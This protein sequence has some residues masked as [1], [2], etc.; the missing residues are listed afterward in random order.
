M[1]HDMKHA[2]KAVI[3]DMDGTVLDTLSE[4]TH[5]L[6]HI[7]RLHHL[8]ELPSQ[9]VRLCLGYGYT[10]LIE[11]A[12]PSVPAET[13]A[14]LAE[15]FKQYYSIHCQGNTHPYNGVTDMLSALR[16]GGY[17]TAIV[18]N[19]GQGAVSLLHDEF[20]H[21]LVDFS[22]GESPQYRKKPAPDMIEK[23]LDLL[24][25]RPEQA[26]YVGDSEVDKETADNAGLT[27]V[28]VTWGFRDSSFLE[29]LHPDYLV[30][31]CQELAR[32][33]LPNAEKAAF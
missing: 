21:N 32:L 23:A 20:F 16:Q 8:P 3:F 5:S 25:C 12:V 1:P 19:K 13:Q 15:E 27:S 11:R 29:T 14:L 10:G 18:S 9:K 31:S 17:K 6:N 30:H 22:L 7:F 4:L 28:L 33:F 26:A 24:G 2:Y